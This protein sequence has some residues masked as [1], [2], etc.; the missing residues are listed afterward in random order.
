MNYF[1]LR[2]QQPIPPLGLQP[3]ATDDG[4]NDPLPSQ[5]APRVDR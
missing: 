3:A 1:S 2:R 5:N 4:N